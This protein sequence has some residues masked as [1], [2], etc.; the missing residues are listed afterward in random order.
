M[1]KTDNNFV[2]NFDSF[3]LGF[4]PL[5]HLDSLTSLGKAGHA[6]AMSNVDIISKPPLLTQGPGLATLTNGTE[7]G[8]VS[9]LINF[10][11]DKAVASDVSYAIGNTKLFKLSS[12]TVASGGT[13]SWPRTITNA[14]GGNSCIEFQGSLYY[15]YNKSSGGDCGKYDL[16]STFDDDWASTVPTGYAALQSAPHPVAKKED[17]MLFANGRYVGTYVSSTTT[18]APTKLDFGANTE[19]ADVAFHANQ[20]YIAV[21]EGIT[22]GTNRASGQIYLYDGAAVSS[23]L[24]D[25]VALGVQKIGWI[26]PVN[27]IV[28]VAYQD[29][30]SA[31][32][33]A[34]GYVSGRQ[35][36]SL[37]F[38][39]GSL[40]TFAQR[41]LYLNTI[42]FI[43]NALVYSA[44][45]VIDK[46]PFQISQLADGGFSTIGAISAP[47]GV[48]LI[49]SSQSTSF[50]LAK[51]SGYDTA[52]NW[53]SIIIPTIS[54]RSLGFIDTIIVLV[55]NLATN[56][57]VSLKIEAN[58]AQS[59]SSAMTI[60][61][62][63]KRRFVFTSKDIGLGKIEDLRLFLDFSG[64]SASANVLVRSIMLIGHFVEA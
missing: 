43:S 64:G 26:Y 13:P 61:G 44:G 2:I 16:A 10:I 63:N 59:T 36:K 41:T 4:A 47:F 38:F 34:I 28:Y 12:T 54:G 9:E 8:V 32:G 52:C 50:K 23:I 22:T 24:S 37:A 33:F 21:N 40:P 18:L 56:A 53:R 14:T 39:T 57:S 48:P 46:L 1:P 3:N 45:A 55:S 25:E 62:A 31:G 51:F 60:T 11:I 6:S 42:L 58:Q 20:W 5:A 49:A 30:S 19:V 29:L 27:G 17:I 7:A 15:F 35:I